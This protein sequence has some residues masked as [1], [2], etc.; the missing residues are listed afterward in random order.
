MGIPHSC[1][2]LSGEIPSR[3]GWCDFAI[4]WGMSSSQVTNSY[5]SEGWLNHQIVPTSTCGGEQRYLQSSSIPFSD[6]PWNQPS[7]ELGVHPWLCCKYMKFDLLVRPCQIC[8]ISC[9][10]RQLGLDCVASLCLSERVH[11][12]YSPLSKTFRL[13]KSWTHGL[14][15]LS[16]QQS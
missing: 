9:A 15:S 10:Q 7:S 13:L 2:S 3:N 8:W 1:H 5:F 12:F 16:H 11:L 4:Y 6:F 14:S